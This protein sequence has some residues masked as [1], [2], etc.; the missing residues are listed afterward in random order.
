MAR[1]YRRRLM[2]TGFE[3]R[4][5][6][7]IYLV[8]NPTDTSVA[9]QL[10]L[11]EAIGLANANAGTDSINFD[12]NVFNA[13]T[14]I[15]L[16]GGPL[17]LTDPVVINGPG[18]TA[19]TISGS[20]VTRICNINMPPGTASVTMSGLTLTHGRATNGTALNMTDGTVILS[21]MVFSFNTATSLGGAIALTT[22]NLTVSNSKFQGN[23]SA[24]SGGAIYGSSTC[25][26]TLNNDQFLANTAAGS[27]GAI[28]APAN[29]STITASLDIFANNRGTSGGAIYTGGGS[30]MTVDQSYFTGNVATSARG[31]A[32]YESANATGQLVITNSTLSANTAI[33]QGGAVLSYYGN[34]KIQ[35]STLTGNRAVNGGAIYTVGGSGTPT[36]EL[37]FVTVSGNTATAGVGGISV[38]ST[39]TVTT[40]TATINAKNAGTTT[41]DLKMANGSTLYGDNNLI[42]V[43]DSSWVTT[44]SSNSN[45][46][47]TANSPLDPL[48]NALTD[49]G[50]G[51]LL[52]DGTRIRTMAISSSQSW[53]YNNGG[54]S[55]FGLLYDE[56]GIGHPRDVPGGNHDIGAYE[57]SVFPE[58]SAKL[59]SAPPIGAPGFAAE[60]ITVVYTEADGGDI[61]GTTFDNNDI[62][63]TGN[64]YGVG[65]AG[66]LGNISGGGSS[67]TVTYTV[68]APAGGWAART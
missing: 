22:G 35:N 28:F 20:D 16:T 57:H 12:S 6:P 13:A 39:I 48:L 44:G 8:D 31:G 9:G 5:V 47:G 26:L 3:E 56:R 33:T 21:N 49:D 40:F 58:P 4:C 38:A 23:T 30:T 60:T 46:I 53:A 29:S 19:L 54:T 65:Q 64:G 41:A 50:T 18:A 11:R 15:T 7:A 68:A 27:G 51:F 43:Q 67:Y 52:P 17:T 10:N 63:V 34:A 61:D 55:T 36:L 24:S 14:T 2:L 1:H 45:F 66:V 37:D 42:G 59:L 62:M 32:I 25:Q